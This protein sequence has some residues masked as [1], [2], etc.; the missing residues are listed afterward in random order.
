MYRSFNFPHKNVDKI[1]TINNND[2]P[3]PPMSV[4]DWGDK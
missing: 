4:S 2:P 1:K 3:D